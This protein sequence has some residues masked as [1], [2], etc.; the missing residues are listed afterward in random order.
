MFPEG[1]G[2]GGGGGGG[3]KPFKTDDPVAKDMA[4]HRRAFLN[5]VAGGES[6]GRYNVRFTPQ[7]GATFEGF[8]DHP[9]IFEQ[10][11]HGP[12]SAAGRYQF[13]ATTWDDMGGGDFSPE[14]QDRRAWDLAAMRYRESTGRDLDA[15]LQARG[16][17][18]D[19]M[20]TLTPTWQAFKGNRDRHIATYNDSMSR[21]MAGFGD[22]PP[23]A[24][25]VAQAAPQPAPRSIVGQLAANAQENM[26]GARENWGVLRRI[27][28]QGVG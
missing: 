24:T 6:N 2:S 13:T 27:M 5:A 16:L 22:A 25:D 19:M 12:S 8:A 3:G 20:E 11:P 4:P 28:T 9:R 7:G 1:G 18:A 17:T 15:D 26:A 10:G 21:Y 14:N 23:A